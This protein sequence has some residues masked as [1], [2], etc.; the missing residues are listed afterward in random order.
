M[1]S[2]NAQPNYVLEQYPTIRLL[3]RSRRLLVFVRV[4]TYQ[5]IYRN[6]LAPLRVRCKILPGGRVLVSVTT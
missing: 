1:A 4:R 3:R 2:I 6:R 5:L